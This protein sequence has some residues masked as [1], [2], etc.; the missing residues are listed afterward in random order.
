MP[1]FL[2][3]IDLTKQELQNAV[4]QVLSSAPGTPAT[5]QVYYNSTS[6]TLQIYN[7]TSW[8]VFG[9]LDQ[10]STAAADVALGSHKITG[11]TDPGA[12]QDAA[13]QNYVLTRSLSAFSAPTGDLAIG[14]NKLTGVKDPTNA[15]DAAT[16][17]YVDNTVNGLDWKTPVRVAS[18]ANV[19]TGSGLA[20]GQ[21]IDGITLA[22]GD[23]VLLKNQSTAGENGIYV[24]P[25]SGAASRSAD[26]T[27]AA[28][29]LQLAVAVEEGTANAD[30]FWVNTTNAPI[31]VGT[32]GLTFSQFGAGATYTNGAGLSLTGNTFAIEGGSNILLPVHGGT[33]VASP[34]AHGVLVGEGASAVTALGVGATGTVLRG[35]TGADPAFGA[36]VLTTDVTGNLPVGNGG[37]GSNTAAG[38]RT[39][40]GATTKYAASLGDG[41]TLSY[42]ITHSLGTTD[43][44]VQ[45]HRVASPFDLV[46]PDIQITDANTVTVIFSVAPSTNQY[47]IVVIG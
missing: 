29:V 46:E 22:T 45:I 19:A 24:S 21:V 43:V 33:G 20:N 18:T 35:A 12:A 41:S 36:V 9:T 31:T 13:T 15:Q 11:V 1:K 26:A 5:G 39:N 27:T 23:R 34:T 16:K 47:R 40:L 7:G 10:I 30:T 42:A 4:V 38:A 14:T 25:A 8:I 2:V 28:Q 6:K 17:N 3:P 32:T 44:L 37:T